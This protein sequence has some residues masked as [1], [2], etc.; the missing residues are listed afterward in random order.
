V[1]SIWEKVLP[2]RKLKIKSGVIETYPTG[3]EANKYN[4]SEMSDGER[5]IFYLIGEVVCSPE[6]SILVIDE[7][8]MHIHK[9]LVKKLLILWRIADQIVL[10]FI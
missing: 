2:H 5:V 6:N 9:S 7:P 4:A 10:S 3:Q 8:E 1:K